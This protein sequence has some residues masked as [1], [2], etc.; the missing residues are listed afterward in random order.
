MKIILSALFLGLI[1]S[2]AVA[3]DQPPAPQSTVF[4]GHQLGE[5]VQQWFSASDEPK[6]C[7]EWKRNKADNKLFCK[8]ADDIAQG[9]SGMLDTR[10]PGD[11]VLARDRWYFQYGKLA[12]LIGTFLPYDKT[13]AELREK[14]GPE[15]KKQA[16]LVV[17]VL[18]PTY[19]VFGEKWAMPDGTLLFLVEDTRA[20]NHANL[21]ISTQAYIDQ[22]QDANNPF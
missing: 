21:V 6:R 18:S 20:V 10:Q 16:K 14:Y 15:T 4:M 1:A 19:P 5:T 13:L 8:V 11:S 17:H 12:A 9:R 3:Q 22:Q 2:L 7:A